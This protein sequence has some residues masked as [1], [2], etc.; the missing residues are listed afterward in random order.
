M[1]LANFLDANS[2]EVLNTVKSAAIEKDGDSLDSKAV[3]MSAFEASVVFAQ[4]NAVR[5][6]G[7]FLYR[8][9]HS[10]LKGGRVDGVNSIDTARQ[11]LQSVT[12]WGEVMTLKDGTK[13]YSGLVPKSYKAYCA[14]TTLIDISRRYGSRALSS[15]RII[16]G[17][18]NN[19][20]IFMEISDDIS[21]NVVTAHI[22]FDVARTT[23]NPAGVRML[24]WF[25]GVERA[26]IPFHGIGSTIVHC[27]QR[28]EELCEGGE[29]ESLHQEAGSDE[30]ELETPLEVEAEQEIGEEGAQ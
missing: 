19:N 1:K 14:Y 5:D 30:L 8:L 27:G 20:D 24:R 16:S 9:M 3:V 29:I 7:R 15:I 17:K 26:L 12:H 21:T 4:R 13:V 25:P 6:H 11:F 2:A 10:A 22:R 23:T 28:L 18:R